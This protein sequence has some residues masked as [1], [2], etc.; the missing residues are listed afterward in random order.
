MQSKHALVFA[1]LA[2]SATVLTQTIP[3]LAATPTSGFTKVRIAEHFDLATGQQPENIA[4][5]PRGAVDLNMSVA[6]QVVRLYPDGR[7]QVLA[8]LPLPADGGV[9]TPL[10][11]F[12]LITGL[13]R[14]DDGTLYFLYAAGTSDQTG[15]WRLRP[16]G[17]PERITAL[18]ANSLPNGLGLDPV[19]G[20]LYSADSA[21]STVWRM[22]LSGGVATAWAGGPELA[23]QGSLGANGL[24]VHKD[25]VWVTNTSL[26]TITRI[27][28]RRHGGAGTFETKATGLPGIDDF[29]FIPGSDR[30]IATLDSQNKVA[31]VEP[32][33]RYT[34]A[35]TG[36]GGLENPTSIAV[37]GHTV[38][39]TSA[40]W[41]LRKDPNLIIARLP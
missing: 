32:N 28:I 5:E 26:G 12:P 24:K 18:P 34:I 40:T 19:R 1:G 36:R 25:A 39:I 10:L 21:L 27:P 2:L 14:D 31:I 15:L 7:R 4:L 9:H 11:G 30:I 37:R 33:G 16:G 8:Q 22:P 38:Y 35:L 41:S 20:E 29:A 23:P 3:A 6:R 13:V 17:T